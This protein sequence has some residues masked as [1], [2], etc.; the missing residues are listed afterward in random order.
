M[1][2]ACAFERD[3]YPLLARDCSFQECHGGATRFFQVFVPGRRR[4]DPKTPILDPVTKD[5]LQASYERTLSMV[6]GFS[7]PK[8]SWLLRKP[9]S[10]AAGGSSHLGIDAFSRNVYPAKD[11]ESWQILLIWAA[12]ESLPCP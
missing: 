8:N 7:N 10:S 9:L 3:V 2:D 5:E 1:L 4:L 11:D 6:A 12:G